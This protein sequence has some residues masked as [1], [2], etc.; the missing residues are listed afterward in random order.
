MMRR[1]SKT[2]RWWQLV[3]PQSLYTNHGHVLRPRAS[4]GL[5][6][7]TRVEPREAWLSSYLSRF[8]NKTTLSKHLNK[9]NKRILQLE[10]SRH[11]MY[12]TLYIIYQYLQN[13]TTRFKF[14]NPMILS[15]STL[16]NPYKTV[17]LDFH[18][19]PH[20]YQRDSIAKT[21]LQPLQNNCTNS[22]F[23]PCYSLYFF[24]YTIYTSNNP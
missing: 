13:C 21:I 18:F 8:N 3:G 11:S 19:I 1:R 4:R 24:Y 20:V 10:I 7:V 9:P 16:L 22:F 12:H 5:R 17:Q 23:Y 2:R 15:L 14:W 6:L